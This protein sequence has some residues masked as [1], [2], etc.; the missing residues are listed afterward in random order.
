LERVDDLREKWCIVLTLVVLLLFILPARSEKFVAL[1]STQNLDIRNI[2]KGSLATPDY[3]S[4]TSG[5]QKYLWNETYGGTAEDAAYSTVSTPDGGFVL[6]GYTHSSSV[7]EDFWLVKTDYFGNIEWNKTYGGPENDVAH[8][9]AQTR[10]GGYAILGTTNSFGAGGSDF[11]LVKT[12]SSGNML[13]NKTYGGT[14]DDDAWSIEKTTDG[15]LVL[16]GWTASFE[17][18]SGDFWL[19]K[20][21]EYGN[22]L[23]NR[24]F[25]GG[26]FDAANC[27]KQTSDGGFALLGSTYSFGNGGSD[28]WLIKTDVSGNEQWNKT[29]GGTA[30]DFGFSLIKTDDGFALVGSTSSY[31]AGVYDFWL[32]KTDQAGN[33]M[34]NQTYGGAGYDEAWSVLQTPNKEYVL[35]GWT[36]SY[37]SGGSD[38]WLVV[39]DTL[40]VAKRS[41]TWG[42]TNDDYAYSALQVGDGNFV[43]AGETQSFGA[44]NSD[45]LLT[46]ILSGVST[47]KTVVGQGFSMPITA[48]VTKETVPAETFNVTACINTTKIGTRPITFE[49]ETSVNVTF[50]WNTTGNAN[51]NYAISVVAEVAPNETYI[52]IKGSVTVTIPGDI[53][54]NLNVQLADLVM[55]ALAYSSQPGN[56]NWKPNADIDG[57][58]VVGLSDLVILALHYGQHYT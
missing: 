7:S 8:S 39:T 35:T 50:T 24:T 53:D 19:V 23:W 45:F 2:G 42:G 25:G 22:M 49:G 9:V 55:L 1:S 28:F 26:L 56:P 58:N 15:S 20:T 47:L 51:G 11:W 4:S 34:W 13:W 44:G 31:G 29:Y 32:V 27:V 40:G 36:E 16:A 38:C 10:D 18:A 52:L 12:D 33:L 17:V 21:D 43:L 37:G 54:G 6:V 5:V 3:I 46:K 57:N 48:T 30:D 41:V 14:S